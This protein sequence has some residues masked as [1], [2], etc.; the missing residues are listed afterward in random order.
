MALVPGK[1]REDESLDT[2]LQRVS[3]GTLRGGAFIVRELGRGLLTTSRRVD[4]LEQRIRRLEA[5]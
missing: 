3:Y 2:Y 4:E 1:R 5:K